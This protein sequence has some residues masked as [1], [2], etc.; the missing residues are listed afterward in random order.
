MLM[1]LVGTWDKYIRTCPSVDFSFGARPNIQYIACC[2]KTLSSA[3]ARIIQTV[4]RIKDNRWNLGGMYDL[5]IPAD[6]SH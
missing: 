4:E 6:M 2:D 1:L 5:D 3:S